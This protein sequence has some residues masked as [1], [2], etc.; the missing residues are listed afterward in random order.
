MT[1]GHA[2][3]MLASARSQHAVST[4]ETRTSHRL[5]SSIWAIASILAPGD[6]CCRRVIPGRQTTIKS[7]ERRATGSLW[8]S[9]PWTGLPVVEPL[10]LTAQSMAR[11]VVKHPPGH[12]RAKH[13]HEVC[14]WLWAR[15]TSELGLLQAAATL[16]APPDSTTGKH[17]PLPKYV[18]APPCAR[19]Y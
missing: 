13:I 17:E 9:V 12:R 5:R 7:K 19:L 15:Q 11:G 18:Y 4:N 3:A 16:E 14:L 2:L 6:H 1:F 10:A 8:S